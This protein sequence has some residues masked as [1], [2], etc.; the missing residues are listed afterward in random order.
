MDTDPVQALVDSYKK[1]ANRVEFLQDDLGKKEDEIDEKA[2]LIGNLEKARYVLSEVQKGTQERFKG[3]V[4]SLVTMAIKSVFD[5]PFGFELIFERK[6][7]KMECR[8]VVYEMVEGDRVEYDDTEYDIGG[9]LVDVMS[10]ALRVVLWSME[11]PRTRNVM[12]LD[13]PGK[14]LG[15]L[16]SL[17]GDIIRKISHELKIQFIVVTHDDA[18]KEVADRAYHISHDGKESHAVLVSG[19]GDIIEKIKNNLSDPELPKKIYKEVEKQIPK[20]RK[21]Q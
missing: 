21:R 17:F 8:P 13:E 18:L 3:Q 12:I 5:R 2:T 9:G 14:N 16:I 10:I 19:K 20:R 7:D 1:L 4:E 15:D 6:R 11:K